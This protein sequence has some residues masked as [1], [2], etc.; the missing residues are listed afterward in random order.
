MPG[1]DP[2]SDDTIIAMLESAAFRSGNLLRNQAIF[3]GLLSFGVRVNELLRLRREELILP[4]GK[5]RR[6]VY[7]KGTK[8]GSTIELPFYNEFGRY[9]I[10]EHLEACRRAGFAYFGD[11]AFPG[12]FGDRPL[13]ECRVWQ[14]IRAAA[15][16]I[17]FEG[18]SGTHSCRKTWA[19][20]T[21]LHY[22]ERQRNGENIE[23]LEQLRRD[24]GW[25][26]ID[27]ARR[28]IAPLLVDARQCQESLYLKVRNHFA[29]T[30]GK[31]NQHGET[32]D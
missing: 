26:T 8:N 21:Y 13:T 16:E 30:K 12:L 19:I 14:I 7:F 18:L 1:R 15:E 9:Y 25:K 32:H 10:W 11:P 3:S 27:A 17:G 4:G 2:F 23:P 20:G 28:Y 22:V 29:I 24:G 31:D 6:V 5:L